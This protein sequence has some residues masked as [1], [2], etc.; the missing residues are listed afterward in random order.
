MDFPKSALDKITDGS[1]WIASP[2]PLTEGNY[3]MKIK[4]LLGTMS[5]AVALHYRGPKNSVAISNEYWKDGV[6][7]KSSNGLSMILM[8]KEK[9]KQGNY[10]FDGDFVYSFQNRIDPNGITYKE[11]VYALVFQNGYSS[12]VMRVD[13]PAGINMWGEMKLQQNIKVP[14]DESATIWGLQGTDK[15]QMS[16]YTSIADTLQSANWA[17][18]IRLGFNDPNNGKTAK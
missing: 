11:L 1:T 14:L 5:G 6:K 7:I 18:A 9:D 8:D 17:M 2:E 3:S 15:Q 10:H 16:T 4:P 13:M 12:S